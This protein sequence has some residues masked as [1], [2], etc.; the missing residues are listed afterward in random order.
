M[1]V[2]VAFEDNTRVNEGQKKDIAKSE[3]FSRMSHDLRSP[4]NSILEFSQSLEQ[5]KTIKENN[6]DQNTV[7]K[8]INASKHSLSIIKSV[9]ESSHIKVNKKL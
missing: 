3:F 4:I 1:E 2:L 9:L 7:S 8:I 5:S 6:Q